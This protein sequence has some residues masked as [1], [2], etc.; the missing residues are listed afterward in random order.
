VPDEISFLRRSALSS[1]AV[2][3]RTRI[4][5][6]EMDSR[7]TTA[8]RKIN[9]LH[10]STFR[11]L[12]VSSKVLVVIYQQQF[13]SDSKVLIPFPDIYIAWR[14]IRSTAIPAS[15]SDV[16]STSFR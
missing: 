3:L 11:A 6:V 16:A 12:L 2:T 13:A 15:K 9:E 5:T 14:V 8:L 7:P 4:S 10:Y 1:C